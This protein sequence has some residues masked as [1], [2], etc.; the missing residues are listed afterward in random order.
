MY[1]VYVSLSFILLLFFRHPKTLWV[2]TM[3]ATQ[4]IAKYMTD[5]L[6]IEI[7]NDEAADDGYISQAEADKRNA[8][9]AKVRSIC[10]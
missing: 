10:F 7:S 2:T 9:W 3:K 6:K 5:S 8:E 4:S 1:A